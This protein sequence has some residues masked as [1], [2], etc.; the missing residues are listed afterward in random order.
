MLVKRTD[1]QARLPGVESQESHC[2]PLQVMQSM[3][4]SFLFCKMGIIIQIPQSLQNPHSQMF[5]EI[6]QLFGFWKGM[7]FY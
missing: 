7:R 6:S 5:L 4:L 2:V 3:Y 1:F